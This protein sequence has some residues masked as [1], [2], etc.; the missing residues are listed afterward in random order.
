MGRSPTTVWRWAAALVLAA[1]ATAA[2]PR[3]L[4]EPA[5]AFR[6]SARALDARSAEIEFRIAKG[7]YMYRERFRFE[8]ESGKQIADAV[9]PPGKVKQDPFFGRTEIYRD[10]VRIRVPLPGADLRRGARLKVTSQGCS[11]TAV[12]YIPQEQWV[13]V[14]LK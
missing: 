5:Q 8:T 7:Y 13:E 4:L 6:L 10:R 1:A 3:E 12:C 2:Q 11:D 9:L 14:R